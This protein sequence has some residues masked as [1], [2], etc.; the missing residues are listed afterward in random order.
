MGSYDEAVRALEEIARLEEEEAE[1]RKQKEEE[2][3]QEILT[4]ELVEEFED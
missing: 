1:A 2:E 4:P 3:L